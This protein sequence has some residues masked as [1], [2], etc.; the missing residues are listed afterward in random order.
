MKLSTTTAVLVL[1]LVLSGCGSSGKHVAT[2]DTAT[3]VTTEKPVSITGVPG[4][5]DGEIRFSAIGTSSNNPPGTCVLPCFADGIKAYFD[6]RNSQ[7]GLVGRKLVLSKVLDDE[8][9]HE[10]GQG[11]RDRDPSQRHVRDVRVTRLATGWT[12][13]AEAGIPTLRVEH[14]PAADGGAAADLRQQRASRASHVHSD[15]MLPYAVAARRE[16]GRHAWLWRQLDS[17][18]C[19][20]T[21]AQSIKAYSA[22][23]GGAKAVYTNDDLAFGLPNGVGPEVTA[24]KEAGVDFIIGC[25]DLNGMKTIAQELVRQGLKIP[26]L[27]RSS[28]DATFIKN[29]ANLFEG[30]IIEAHFRPF[31]ANT[32]STLLA[33]FK[34]QMSKQG[35]A[36]TEPAMFGWIAADMAYNGI[37][38]A[39]Q[40]FD[41]KKVIDA[42]N[43]KA[44]TFTAGGLVPPL[45][46][47]QQHVAPTETDQSHA[48][49][50]DCNA[51]LKVTNGQMSMFG[52][53]KDKPF[54]C[55][56][57]DTTAWSEPTLMN[58]K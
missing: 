6:Y 38:L 52:G 23:I 46:F 37:K 28:Y 47:G 17:K 14:Q 54:V 50:Y 12:D 57:G 41:R 8:L 27:H 20:D 16:E 48:L 44:T 56:P 58:F 5:T 25:L 30:N 19:A 40:P 53:T 3:T 22:D 1:A 43:T 15:A 11:A 35:K 13:L 2:N 7:G 10:P 33:S 29:N 39:G 24:M 32:A 36:Q 18:T 34:A 9:G 26:M 21:Y 49:Q 55:F 51:Y 4:V 42:L 45:N 31:E